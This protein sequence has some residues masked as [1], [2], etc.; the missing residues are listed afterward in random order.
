DRLEDDEFIR[1]LVEEELMAPIQMQDSETAKCIKACMSCSKACW[2]ALH[3]LLNQ[4][5]SGAQGRHIATLQMCAD[6]CEL[7]SKMMLLDLEFSNQSCGLA[8]ELSTTCASLCEKYQDE[9]IMS[10][11]AEACR[12]CAETTRG[13]AGM[14]VRMTGTPQ[15][16]SRAN[17]L[18]NSSARI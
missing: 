18:M 17:N 1:H 13:M 11:C 14:T 15:E 6:V 4:K 12:Y 3:F 2:D 7:S 9:P 16:L 8:F 5:V 10:R